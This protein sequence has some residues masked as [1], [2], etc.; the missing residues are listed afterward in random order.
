MRCVVDRHPENRVLMLPSARR[1]WI[2]HIKRLCSAS[3]H[4]S[5]CYLHLQSFDDTLALTAYGIDQGSLGCPAKCVMFTS[6]LLPHWYC[7]GANSFGIGVCDQ[8]NPFQ[9]HINTSVR[10]KQW[11]PA[12]EIR[13]E[14]TYHSS[15]LP[16]HVVWNRLELRTHHYFNHWKKLMWTPIFGLPPWKENICWVR[17][18]PSQQNSNKNMLVFCKPF[19]ATQ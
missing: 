11:T 19:T 18:T 8:M 14:K 17:H 1:R 12:F 15:K 5:S 3:I 7:H 16:C 13:P 10:V 6:S 2:L 9:A 4:L